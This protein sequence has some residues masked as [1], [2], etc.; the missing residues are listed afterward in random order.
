MRPDHPPTRRHRAWLASLAVSLLATGL[1]LATPADPAG[2]APR[3]AVAGH[4]DWG[5]KASF[6]AYVTGPIAGG[7]ITTSGGA[8]TNMDGTFRFPLASGSRDASAETVSSSHN[9]SVRFVGHSGALDLTL[10]DLRVSISGTTGSLVGDARTKGFAD[11]TPVLYDDVTLATLDLTS[12]TPVTTADTA[13]YS[14]VPVSLTA[15]GS[16]AFAGFY[17]AGTAMDPLTL[18]IEHAPVVPT[19]TVSKTSGIHPEGEVVTVSGS[20]FDPSANLST[21]PPVPTGMPAGVYVVFGRFAPVWKPSAGAPSSARQVISQRWAMPQASINAAVA[22]FGPNP[23]YVPLQPDGT[24]TTTLLVRPDDTKT[25]TYAVATWAGGGAVP[26]PAQE[27]FTPIS[28]RPATG[29]DA[30]ASTVVAFKGHRDRSRVKVTVTNVGTGTLWV[31]GEDLTFDVTRDGSPTGHEIIPKA[32]S[33]R[34][35]PPGRSRVFV[36]DWVHGPSL[37]LADRFVVR[38][39]VQLDDDRHSNDCDA[40]T[41]PSDPVDLSVAATAGPARL[42]SA[43]WPVTVAVSNNGAGPVVVRPGDVSFVVTRNG[44]PIEVTPTPAQD[45][46]RRYLLR[47]GRTLKIGFSLPLSGMAE[48]DLV[49]L[50]ACVSPPSDVATGDNCAD[51]AA[52]VVR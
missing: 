14:G 6:R 4:L 29:I 15:A 1:V 16:T 18:R 37:T 40:E 24:F 22:A 3:P 35:L 43:S 10:S 2:A 9:G 17:P 42:R 44:N 50:S 28:F 49:E 21:R 26:N 33:R 13:T 38:G 34:P 11:P 41:V 36:A 8:S 27:L 25:G 32:A 45:P 46:A 23:Q 31:G 12:I 47:P 20:G 52:S 51:V 48:G 5:V 19:I 7:S 39:C 30:A